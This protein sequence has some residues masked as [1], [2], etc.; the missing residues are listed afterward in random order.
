[1]KKTFLSFSILLALST[2]LFAGSLSFSEEVLSGPEKAALNP[3]FIQYLQTLETFGT[4]GH[5]PG[6]P[7]F[8]LIPS[9]LD[10]SHLKGKS[11]FKI[12]ESSALPRGYDL[13]TH[14]K[15][16]SVKAQGSC[17][18][19]WAFAAYGSLESNFL[20]GE[21]WDFSENHMKNT[22]GFDWDSCEGGNADISTAYLARGSG[23]VSE[24]DDPYNPVSPYSPPGL[25]ARKLI[26]NV[27][28]LPDRSG[29]LDNDDM[30]QAVMTYGGVY[31]TMYYADAYFNPAQNTYYF[32]GSSYGNH[33]VVIVGWDDDFDKGK[34]RSTPAGNGAFIIKNSWGPSWG[35][36]GFFYLSYYDSN[37]GIENRAFIKGSDPSQYRIYQHD[38][39]GWTSSWSYGTPTTGWFANVFTAAANDTLTAVSFFTTSSDATYEVSVYT[40]VTSGPTTGS[41]AGSQSGARSFPGYHT[42]A[43]DSSVDL[44]AGQKF[45]IVV[46]VEIP[47]SGYPYPIPVESYHPGYSSGATANPGESFISSKGTSWKDI[48]SFAGEEDTN[49]CIKAFTTSFSETVSPPSVLS[50]PI[51]GTTG[52]IYTYST[53]GASSGLGHSVQ[54]LFDWGDGTTSGWLAE[55]AVSASKTWKS[56]ETFPVKVKARCTTHTSVESTWSPALSVTVT[57]EDI[58]FGIQPQEGTVG[59]DITLTGDAFG[60]KK[61]KVFLGGTALK[62]LTWGNETIQCRLTKTV[63]PGSY[64]IRVQ[65]GDGSSETEKNGFVVKLPDIQSITHDHGTEGIE[66]TLRGK[67]FGGS[68]GKVYVESKSCRV[69]SRSV[70]P[71]T[72]EETFIF[73][74]PKKLPL[75]S[76][77]ITLTSKVGSDTWSLSIE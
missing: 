28:T 19:C 23:P 54:Y 58:Y 44:S 41:F 12:E 70:A 59:T 6:E 42:I 3:E 1:M 5:E 39:L 24:S 69:I 2:L 52:T 62:V 48:T 57:G 40:G 73:L 34:F 7:F 75:G 14:G 64:D 56:S 30:K 10:R 60:S 65:R 66:I 67:H 4:L 77:R 68:K 8:G 38:P 55:G 71:A 74:F 72:G 22:H 18:S 35:D 21:E 47:D 25:L 20:P 46:K 76:H 53:G 27:L 16:T 11:I 63:P 61:G 9:P 26:Q 50:G 32:T 49:V 15:V 29:P 43:L 31:T 36:S 13:R 33:G 17:G 45:S 37:V 51:S